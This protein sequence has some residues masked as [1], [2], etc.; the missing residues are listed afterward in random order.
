MG[1]FKR[2]KDMSKA[3]VNEWLDKV[4]DPVAMINQYIRDMQ[5]EIT[6]AEVTVAKQMANERMLKER[7]SDSLARS[8][9]CERR[10]GEALLSGQ[11]DLAR[12][13]LEEKLG[14]DERAQGPSRP[15]CPV[16]SPSR[17]AA[18]PAS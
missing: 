3:G 4:E 2:M 17:R 6:K 16:Q 8:T 10:A 13:L 1:V 7:L 11:E 12:K 14:H 15:S 9:A 18:P 5:E